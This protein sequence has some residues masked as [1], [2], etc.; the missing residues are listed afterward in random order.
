MEP[1]NGFEECITDT[2]SCRQNRYKSGLQDKST[3]FGEKK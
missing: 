2:I 3:I 1:E